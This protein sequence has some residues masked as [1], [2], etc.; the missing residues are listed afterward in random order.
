M[1]FV[2]WVAELLPYK[3]DVQRSI[4]GVGPDFFDYLS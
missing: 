3:P 4:P 1:T 2:D